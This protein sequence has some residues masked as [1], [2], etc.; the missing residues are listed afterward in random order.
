MVYCCDDDVIEVDGAEVHGNNNTVSGARSAVIGNGNR[1]TGDACTITGDTNIV[2]GCDAVVR[3]HNNMVMGNGVIVHGTSNTITGNARE[4]VGANNVVEPDAAPPATPADAPP[5][6]PFAGF[7][8]G[9]SPAVPP[10][11][12]VHVTHPVVPQPPPHTTTADAPPVNPFAGFHIGGSL[13]NTP[14]TQSFRYL[15][16]RPPRQGFQFLPASMPVHSAAASPHILQSFQ[17][18]SS[19]L[20]AGLPPRHTAP[21]VVAADGLNAVLAGM[22]TRDRVLDADADERVQCIICCARFKCVAL[23]PCGHVEMCAECALTL[24]TTSGSAV[25]CPICKVA[26]RN[27]AFARV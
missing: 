14:T 6:N 19:L 15:G 20:S 2:S 24:V 10:S 18:P 5:V 9:R 4:I 7:H 17:F 3:G 13:E 1:V 22:K 11:P 25:K 26:V 21:S 16:D 27:V 8:T 23:D 12:G